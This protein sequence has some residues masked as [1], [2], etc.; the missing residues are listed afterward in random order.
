MLENVRRKKCFGCISVK[1]AIVWA[2]VRMVI[3]IA[4]ILLPTLVNF[5]V[6]VTVVTIVTLVTMVINIAKVTVG[7]FSGQPSPLC[8]L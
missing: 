4:I 2:L 5:V 8:F 6:N 3:N 7:T 1:R